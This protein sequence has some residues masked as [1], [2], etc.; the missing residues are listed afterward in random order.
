MMIHRDL[1]SNNQSDKTTRVGNESDQEEPH[2]KKRGL[3]ADDCL[4]GEMNS[5]EYIE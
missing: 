5:A 2:L 3:P 4:W 1:L